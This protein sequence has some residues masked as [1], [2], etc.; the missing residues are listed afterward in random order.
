[1]SK[2]I[3]LITQGG[4]QAGKDALAKWLKEVYGFVSLSTGEMTRLMRDT[5][6]VHGP[7][8]RADQDAGVLIRNS[9]YIP[10]VKSVWPGFIASSSGRHRLFNGAFRDV[11]Q[12]RAFWPDLVS[13]RDDYELLQIQLIPTD[14][15]L[16][17][18]EQ[19]AA[20]A[21][22]RGPRTDGG[23]IQLANA[24]KEFVEKTIP[25][26][27][28]FEELGV[29][30]IRLSVGYNEPRESVRYRASRALGLEYRPT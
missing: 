28:L 30:T 6:P 29:P 3:A 26:I 12:V 20:A 25:A 21:A 17:R 2:N 15:E 24:R 1:M 19:D 23:E 10:I 7:V 4:R 14:D 18:R 22:E 9:A 5:D 8:I 27:Q 16:R 11:E 13:L